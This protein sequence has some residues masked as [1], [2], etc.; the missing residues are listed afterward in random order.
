MINRP[1]R[2]STAHKRDFN[3]YVHLGNSI[4]DWSCSCS[5]MAPRSSPGVRSNY[6][7]HPLDMTEISS[8]SPSCP[9]QHNQPI[10]SYFISSC[11]NPSR[12]LGRLESNPTAES[13]CILL[14]LSLRLNNLSSSLFTLPFYD[15]TNYLHHYNLIIVFYLQVKQNNNN[16]FAS[17]L[18]S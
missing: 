1:M 2:D 4:K 9:S 15:N 12:G 16:Q 5:H 11:L 18:L 3:C 7:T 14:N 13:S 10:N 8:Y 6:W 17:Y